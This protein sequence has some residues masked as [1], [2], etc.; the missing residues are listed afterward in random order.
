MTR[1]T[2]GGSRFTQLSKGLVR[3][4]GKMNKS[5][6]RY[7]DELAIGKRTGA[8]ADY[9]FEP[10]S[11]RI[12]ACESGQPARYTPDFMVL[13]PDGRTFLDDVKTASGFDDPAALVRIKVAASEYPLWVFRIVRPAVGGFETQEI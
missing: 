13:L 5:E 2:R 11:L 4:R 1:R 3:T 9:W 6:T 7:A 8:I 12:S 10:F